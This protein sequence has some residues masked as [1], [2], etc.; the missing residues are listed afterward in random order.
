MNEEIKALLE[1]HNGD[2]RECLEWCI[3][4]IDAMERDINMIKKTL[5]CH[6]EPRLMQ[7]LRDELS[8]INKKP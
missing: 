1:R 5:G 7:D 3:G 4:Y 2:E 8:L 6:R